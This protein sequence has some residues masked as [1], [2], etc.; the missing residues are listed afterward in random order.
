MSENKCSRK[1]RKNVNIVINFRRVTH[2]WLCLLETQLK[3]FQ[4]IHIYLKYWFFAS[5]FLYHYFFYFVR[6]S[7]CIDIF[8]F[9]KIKLFAKHWLNSESYL[10]SSD[11]ILSLQ[12]PGGCQP[13]INSMDTHYLFS[14]SLSLLS[15][16]SIV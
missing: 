7:W 4:I 14:I 15:R 2:I 10:E 5:Y 16:H 9:V 12:G 13:T 1:R 11:K 3:Y 6:L 8:S